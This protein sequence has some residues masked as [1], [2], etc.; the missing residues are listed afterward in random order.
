MAAGLPWLSRKLTQL[1][2]CNCLQNRG[3]T[4]LYVGFAVYLRWKHGPAPKRK[5][6]EGRKRHPKTSRRKR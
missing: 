3:R 4:I 2:R 6:D 5:T 1:D